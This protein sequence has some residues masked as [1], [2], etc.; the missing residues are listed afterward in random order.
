MRTGA[1]MLLRLALAAGTLASVEG[2]TRWSLQPLPPA[3]L[4]EAQ[5]PRHVQ[6]RGHDGQRIVLER[7]WVEGDALV[8]VQRHD[9][10]R[11]ALA[12]IDKL[13]VRRFDLLKTA[14]LTIVTAG[15]VLGTAC[16]LACDFGTIG[17]G[18]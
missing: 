8:G 3:Q 16:A 18:Y 14:G 12:D 17:F 2:C 15:V 1:T 11:V 5:R 7:P 6:T 13:A 10:I 9:T 4:V